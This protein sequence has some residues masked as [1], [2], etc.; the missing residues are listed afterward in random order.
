MLGAPTPLS[1]G[2][3][4]TDQN[5]VRQWHPPKVDCPGSSERSDGAVRKK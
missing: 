4:P 3:D 5:P 1:T 2:E